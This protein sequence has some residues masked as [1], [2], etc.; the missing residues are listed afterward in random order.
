MPTD[1]LNVYCILSDIKDT[2]PCIMMIIFASEVS[3]YFINHGHIFLRHNITRLLISIIAQMFY[4]YTFHMLGLSQIIVF[5]VSFA[6][7]KIS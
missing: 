3:Q 4:Q 5:Y 6:N 7:V 1:I 2:R